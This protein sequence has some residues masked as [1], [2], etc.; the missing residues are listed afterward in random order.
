MLMSPATTSFQIP[1][2]PN[3]QGEQRDVYDK[4]LTETQ[5]SLAASKLVVACQLKDSCGPIGTPPERHPRQQQQELAGSLAASRASAG[6][7]AA[8][9]S[10]TEWATVAVVS[11]PLLRLT[12]GTSTQAADSQLM[13]Q[14]AGK[15]GVCSCLAACMLSCS[16]VLQPDQHRL[17]NSSAPDQRQP[18]PDTAVLPTCMQTWKCTPAPYSVCSWGTHRGPG[19]DILGCDILICRLSHPLLSC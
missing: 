17:H 9:S 12:A 7:H 2:R 3:E 13:S 11:L 16:S 6:M 1:Q 10:C 4:L 8:G 15:P 14:P 19:S 18:D 5:D